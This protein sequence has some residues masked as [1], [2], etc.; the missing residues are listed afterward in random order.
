MSTF[1]ATPFSLERGDLIKVRASAYNVNGWSAVSVTNT[2]GAYVMTA[3][4][5]M[6]APVRD[7][8]SSD[9]QIIVTWSPLSGEAYTGGALI[10]SYGLEWDEGSSGSS[11][12]ELTGHTVRTLA[13]SF[14]VTSGLTAG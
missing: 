4:T 6:E 13:T 14:T 12:E 9:S 3:P 2:A 7:S 8:D 5:Y 11:W 10:I 1:T